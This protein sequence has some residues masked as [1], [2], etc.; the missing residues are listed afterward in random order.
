M[1]KYR[2]NFNVTIGLI[3]LTIILYACKNGKMIPNDVKLFAYLVL[4]SINLLILFKTLS[5]TKPLNSLLN[6][7]LS[8]ENAKAKVGFLITA[9]KNITRMELKISSGIIVFIIV[10]VLEVILFILECWGVD[11]YRLADIILDMIA[12]MSLSNTYLQLHI[13]YSIYRYLEEER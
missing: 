5:C 1:K 4:V 3:I 8:G 6:H 2:S 12:I 7:R 10:I 9:I 11:I 13:N